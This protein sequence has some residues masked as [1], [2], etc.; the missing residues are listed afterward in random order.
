MAS[1][2]PDAESP[3]ST[4]IPK[5][6]RGLLAGKIKGRWQSTQ[7]NVFVLL[8]LDKYFQ[9]YEKTT[10]NFVAKVWL[11]KAFAGERKFAGR[12]T[13]SNLI[14]V[15]MNYLRKSNDAKNLI[16]DRQGR[17]VKRWSGYGE[18]MAKRALEEVLK[19]R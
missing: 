17:L 1:A 19:G 12:S 4:L 2:H 15:P 14:S 6:V 8:A 13:D 3:A 7:E 10:P 18:G 11:G 9:T 16:I 5:I